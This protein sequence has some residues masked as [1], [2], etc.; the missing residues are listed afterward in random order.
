LA[1]LDKEKHI[2]SITKERF[3]T[4]YKT[5]STNYGSDRLLET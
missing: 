3:Y 4:F 5:K 1:F 2:F